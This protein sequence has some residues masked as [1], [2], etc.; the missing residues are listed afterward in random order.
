MAR[1][2]ITLAGDLNLD[3]IL[4]GVPEELPPERD[5]LASGM[6]L[7]LG[8]SSAIVAHNLAA[9]GCRVGFQARL[10]HDE[11]GELLLRRMREIGVDVSKV[12]T[13]PGDATGVTVILHRETWRNT[14]SF[15]GTITEL[16]L[17]D[18]DFD[19]LTDSRHFHLSSFYLQKKLRPAV[20]ELFR[21]LK[22]AGV[23]ISLDTNDDPEDTWAG[24]LQDAL[25][26]V[27]VFMP[28]EREARK[29]ARTDDL[30]E[31]M[32]RLARLVPVL[33]VK[34]GA[35][36]SIAYSEGKR[37]ASPALKVRCVDA[38]GAGDSFDAGFLSEFVRG[39]NL[40]KC[41][42]AGNAAGALSVTRGGGTEAF[43]D[44]EYRE[45]FLQKHSSET[46]GSLLIPPG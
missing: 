41:L 16:T 40:E 36:G 14:V 35:E 44:H 30:E 13:L 17:E 21:K 2:D 20:P 33:V 6:E 29:A 5:M 15:C 8:G 10:A 12:R 42:A 38:V 22:S 4:H 24:G 18:L 1:F 26:Y 43:R 31:A 28:N 37:I 45:Q 32:Q 46:T 39:G 9:L 23:T 7:T 3:F 11:F 34:L 27:D 25:Q 19:Y